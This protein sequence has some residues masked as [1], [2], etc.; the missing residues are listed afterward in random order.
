MHVWINDGTAN[1]GWQEDG[2]FEAQ[3][4]SGSGICP[5][6][7]P[8]VITLQDGHLY[9]IVCVDAADCGMNDPTQLSCR[10]ADAI[11]LGDSH[12]PSFIVNVV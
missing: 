9:E 12:G 10:A 5:S 8:Y 7:P 11:V 3:D 4:D 1:T 2:V 6:G